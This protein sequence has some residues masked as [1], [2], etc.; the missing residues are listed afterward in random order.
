MKQL[1]F[2][3]LSFLVLNTGVSAQ[4]MDTLQLSL[5]KAVQYAVSNNAQLKSTQLNEENN[6]YKIKEIKSSALPQISGSGSF[7]DNYSIATQLLPG[8]L[9]GQPGQN[10]PVKFG[11]RFQYGPSIRLSQTLFNPSL[12]AGIKAAKES[13]GLFELQSFKSKEELIYNVVNVYIQLQMAEKQRELIA[14]NIDRMTKLV[15]ITNAQFKEG[16]IKKVDVEQL[17]VNYTNLQTQLSN[18]DNAIDQLLNNLKMLMNID[19]E[20][21]IAITTVGMQATAVSRQLLMEDN[22]DLNIVE[23]QIRLQQLNTQNIKA[24]YLPTVSLSANYGRTWQTNK[25]FNDAATSGF[26]AGYYSINLSIPIFDG[27]TKRHQIAQS[28]ISL[29]QLQLSKDFLTKSVKNQF[30]TASNNLS[31]NQKVLLAQGENMRV[32]EELY[33]VAKLSYTEGITALSELINAENSLREAQS[34]YLT[35]MLQMNIAELELM[36]TSGQLSQLIK[37]ASG[38]K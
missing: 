14:G 31:Q 32:A 2:L 36:Q 6:R 12:S 25:L 28:N 17:K 35:A 33:T 1:F 38:L 15:E 34:Q 18:T 3:S 9:L 37:T 24:G 10:I 26:S 29:K 21:P 20:R 27:F 11:T 16:I 30:Q 23:K 13:Q 19:V 8:E 4:A 7:T 5:L 22:T